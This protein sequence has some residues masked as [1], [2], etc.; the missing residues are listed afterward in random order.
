MYYYATLVDALDGLRERGYTEDFQI[1]PDG[2]EW[3]EQQTLLSPAD[4][5]ITEVYRFEGI[6]DPGDNSIVYAVEGKKGLRGVVIDAYGMY[7]DNLSADMLE[8]LRMKA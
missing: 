6:S 1:K 2:M 4:F 7:S 5:E 3:T 8:K